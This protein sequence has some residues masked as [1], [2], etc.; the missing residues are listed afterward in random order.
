MASQI[1][2]N[3]LP[4]TQIR[5]LIVDDESAGREALKALLNKYCPEISVVAD[6]RSIRDALDTVENVDLVFLDIELP[7]GTG[8]DLLDEVTSR[9]FDV[10]FVT[11]YD[12][13][14]IQA[15]KAAAA[16]YLL[17]PVSPDELRLAV[18]RVVERHATR[19]LSMVTG[20]QTTADFSRERLALPNAEG[21]VIVELD[22]IVRCQSHSNYTEFHTTD[23]RSILVSRSMREYERVLTPGGFVRIH[24]SHII[25]LRYVRNYVRGKGGYVVM[26]DGSHVDVSVR[27]KE[28]FLR[29]LN[30]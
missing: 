4:T 10:I 17:K 18:Q 1:T 22:E 11:A 13:Y 9:A 23:G 8:F 25:N 7:D 27:R 24:N 26:A 21:L 15:V 14:G 16:D 30:G 5:S 3:N 12:H 29:M 6:A 2:A 19:Q 28:A 20:Q